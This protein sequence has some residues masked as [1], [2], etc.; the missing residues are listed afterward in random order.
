[1]NTHFLHP[2]GLHALLISYKLSERSAFSSAPTDI[3]HSIASSISP[4][5]MGN[6]LKQNFKYSG[7]KTY[8]ELEIPEFAPL[9]FP[10][11]DA[12]VDVDG[13]GEEAKKKQNALKKSSKFVADYM[14]RR[15]Q[16]E[17]NFDNP[18]SSLSV[19]Q[20]KPFAS[21]YSDP[22][23]PVNSGSLLSLVTGGKVDTKG[24]R[25]AHPKGPIGRIRV[26]TGTNKPIKKILR[27]NVLYLMIVNMPSEEELKQARREMEAEKEGK[28]GGKWKEGKE[29]EMEM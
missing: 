22:N 6:K 13:E 10:Y 16:A 21:R 1:M 11:L 29:E 23:Q 24:Y 17:Y 20:D 18:G 9:I 4:E 27:Q 15:A 25:R 3:S 19:P 7:G 26:A 14:D 5:G 28:K 8:G 2:R 12:A